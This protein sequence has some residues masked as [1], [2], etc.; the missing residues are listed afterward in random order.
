VDDL[1]AKGTAAQALDERGSSQR[2]QPRLQ[3]GTNTLSATVVDPT[4]KQVPQHH[5][6]GNDDQK[7]REWIIKAEWREQGQS[8]LIRVTLERKGYEVMGAIGGRGQL[9]TMNEWWQ[10]MPR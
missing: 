6:G 1:N 4:A 7:E 9:D 10:T 3:P 5:H 2:P 8:L